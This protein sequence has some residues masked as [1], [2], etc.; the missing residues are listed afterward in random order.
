MLKEFYVK[1]KHKKCHF[2]QYNVVFLGYVLSVRVSLQ[3]P[4][5]WKSKE[6]ASATKPKS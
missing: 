3:T 4:K 2:F 5:N 6:M 1:I